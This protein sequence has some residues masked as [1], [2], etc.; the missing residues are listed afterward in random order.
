LASPKEKYYDY[1]LGG[2]FLSDADSE[3]YRRDTTTLSGAT[4]SAFYGVSNYGTNNTNYSVFGEGHVNLTP[5]LRAI[6]GGRLVHDD[7]SYHFARIGNVTVTEPGIQTPF[8]S[9][10]STHP[11][12]VADRAGLEYD[13]NKSAMTYFTY[14]RGYKGPAYNVSFSMLPQ[15]T[16]A[17]KPE[18]SDD[19]ELGIKFH[20]LNGRLVVNTDA[21]IDD[22][23][24]FQVNFAD[25]LNGSAITRL[26]NA[27]KVS[28]KGIESDV[29]LRP[30]PNL[31][32]T[33]NAAYTDATIDQFKCP[34]GTNTSCNVNGKPLP[35]APK[36]KSNVTAAYNIAL[37]NSLTL[38]IE[39]D[40]NWQSQNQQ[41]ITQ[42]P[43]TIE[44]AYGIWNGRISIANDKGWY[45]AFLVKNILN[46]HY[47]DILTRLSSG[48]ARYVP[49]DDDRYFGVDLRRNF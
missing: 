3:M 10:G 27:G 46:Q 28:T 22:V 20:A 29:E 34:V 19:Y 5:S 49:R 32:L 8:A 7:L 38:Q 14:S 47:D 41:S 25:T 4:Q 2:Y 13:I 43:D 48:L 44:P 31:V 30:I 21:F 36:W 33:G 42:T 24:D 11:S 6:L 17:L 39:S 9:V 1:V 40:A 37:P 18:I 23:K 26:I 45:A 15:D 16:L 12:G 35:F